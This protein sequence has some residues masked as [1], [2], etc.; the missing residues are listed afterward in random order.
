MLLRGAGGGF[1]EQPGSPFAAGDGPY[2]LAVGDFDDDGR[3]DLAASN[4]TLRERHGPA[5]RAPAAGSPPRRSRRCAVGRGPLQL[6]AADL[7][8]DRRLDLVVPNSGDGT[9][10]VLLQRRPAVPIDRPGPAVTPSPIPRPGGVFA[11]PPQN[12]SRPT[13]VER[14]NGLL[15]CSPGTWRDLPSG[16]PLAYEWLIVDAPRPTAPGKTQIVSTEATFAQKPT[17]IGKEVACRVTARNGAG[18]TSATSATWLLAK[19]GPVLVGDVYGNFRIRGID[20]FQTVQPNSG[21]AMYDVPSGA[22]PVVFGGGTPTSSKIGEDHQ[23]ADYLGVPIDASKPAVA[24]VYLDM[25]EPG[26]SKRALVVTLSARRN[27]RTIDGTQTRYVATPPPRSF[28]GWVTTAERDDP[29][30]GVQFRVPARWLE[31]AATGDPLE[32]VAEVKLESFASRYANRECA[33]GV[34]CT[35]DNVYRLSGVTSSWLFP[36]SLQAVELRG[37]NQAQG[38]LNAPDDVLARAMQLYPGGDGFAVGAYEGAIDV[39]ALQEVDLDTGFVCVAFET[40]RDCRAGLI[41]T[42]VEA[43]AADYSRATYARP[44]DV[45]VGIHRYRVGNAASNFEPGWTAAGTGTFTVNDGSAGRPLT[46]AA[47]EFGHVMGAVHASTG[48]GGG[49]DDQIGESW[50]PDQ[51]GRLQGVKFDNTSSH[52]NNLRVDP[53][54]DGPSAVFDLM[55]YCAP[56]TSAWLSA[57]NW[58]RAF[59]WLTAHAALH[60]HE[61]RPP[62]RARTASAATAAP[63][64]SA[65]A[66]GVVGSRGGAITRIV[67]ADGDDRIPASVP[68][69]DVRLRSLDANGRV[70]LDAGVEVH[71]AD[72]AEDGAGTFVGPVTPAAA[73]VELVRDGTVLNRS[74]RS[75]APRVGRLAVRSRPGGDVRV[76]WAASDPDG[77]PLHATIDYSS[78]GGRS[79]RP[80]YTGPNRGNAVLDA[81]FMEGSRRARV[82]VSIDDGFSETRAVSALLQ[83]AGTRPVVTIAGPR[84]GDDLRAG[85][86]SLLTG[87]AQDD[88]R[89]R[90]TR[91][92]LTWYAGAKRLGTGERLSARL[93]AGKVV[94]RLVA[95]DRHGR[96]SEARRILRV[97]R[98]PLSLSRLRYA[99]R[100][101][102]GTRTV[103]VQV[104]TSAAGTLRAGA[105]RYAVGPRLRRIAVHLPARPVTGRVNV[106]FTLTPAAPGSGGKTLGTL[107]ILRLTR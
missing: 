45:T 41:Q 5:R 80:L 25:T 103:S 55:S 48:C 19:A 101:R 97:Q 3:T 90:L 22:F 11:G 35:A 96:T 1:A 46:A 34:A 44:A 71:A 53:V 37:R 40:V 91:R 43:W 86:N 33:V 27:G 36:L 30:Y 24:T 28:T 20:I 105:R 68:A 38:S 8:G 6:A 79:Y 78:D 65:F 59:Q 9:V 49:A 31:H 100:V 39:S 52:L 93:P 56:E 42:V 104:Q 7:D 61:W 92:A 84:S 99:E 77:D 63:A 57:R 98:A 66:T 62:A 76:W 54:V 14:S 67:V 64:D 73:A 70:L 95:R 16:A 106:P 82:R 2:G 4:E 26:S 21:A 89:R 32:L 18:A 60:P 47:H 102:A 85:E 74:E 50:P 58:N 94:L 88:G 51:M 29:R 13:V 15:L 12:L 83:V 10:S 69:A 23:R 107:T 72:H 75:R 81:A 17:L 87:S